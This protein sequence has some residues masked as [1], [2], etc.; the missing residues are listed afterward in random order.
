MHFSGKDKSLKYINRIIN[1]DR[2]MERYFNA[3]FG[4]MRTGEGGNISTPI[5]KTETPSIKEY[6]IIENR[7]YVKKFESS[8]ELAEKL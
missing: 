3:R 2:N 8:F 4:Q 1:K 6:I 5:Q 7:N